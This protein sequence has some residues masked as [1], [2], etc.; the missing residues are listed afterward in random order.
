MGLRGRPL[1]LCF[2]R[3]LCGLIGIR[4]AAMETKQRKKT[5]VFEPKPSE[6]EEKHPK[7]IYICWLLLMKQCNN[8]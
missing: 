7:A 1:A 2:T 5:M 3:M 8:Q 4:Y 6:T